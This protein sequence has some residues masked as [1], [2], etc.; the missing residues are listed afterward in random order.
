MGVVGLVVKIVGALVLVVAALGAYLYFTDYEA[1][2]AVTDRASDAACPASASQCSVT[3]TPKL[4]PTWHYA[5]K[6]DRQYW[7]VVCVGYEVHFRVQTHALQVF[8]KSGTLV[9][10][11]KDP[12]SVNAAALLKCGASN[13]I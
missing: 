6:V 11:S 9:Y 12:N 10:D 8:D 2:A 5:T 7:Q 13:V 3:V 1:R 4:F